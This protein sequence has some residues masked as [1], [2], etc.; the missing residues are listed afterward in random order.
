[1]HLEMLSVF[2]CQWECKL[3]WTLRNLGSQ[4]KLLCRAKTLI[5]N[6]HRLTSEEL[7]ACCWVCS[8]YQKS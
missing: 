3:I 8:T 7:M 2:H 4:W 5:S 6:V 1:M